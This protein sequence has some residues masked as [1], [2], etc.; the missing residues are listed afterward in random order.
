M[1]FNSQ[2]SD[3]TWS[4]IEEFCDEGISEG[5]FLDY[6]ENFPKSLEKTISALAKTYGGIILIGVEEDNSNKPITPIKG[7]DFVRGLSEKVMH[8][9][10]SNISPPIIPEIKGL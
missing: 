9:I 3:I 7:I 4:S 2:I 10:L 5:T 6:K 1:I 8:I